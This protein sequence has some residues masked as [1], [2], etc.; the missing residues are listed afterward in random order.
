MELGQLMGSL[1]RK[2]DAASAMDQ[3]KVSVLACLTGNLSQSALFASARATPRLPPTTS[4]S[5]L[6][7]FS[8]TPRHCLV[9]CAMSACDG[10][11]D[12]TLELC[13]ARR[14]R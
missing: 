7:L 9:T 3:I 2:D 5:A 13:G 10:I 4:W 11:D 8:E 6:L 14:H 1:Q 12:N